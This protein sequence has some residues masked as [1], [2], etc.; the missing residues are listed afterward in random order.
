MTSLSTSDIRW[1]RYALLQAEQAPH[2]RWR[3][4]AVLIRGGSV[5]STGFNRYRNDPAQVEFG[6]A[7]YHAEEVAL[8]KAGDAEGSTI[9]VARI[10]RSG[11]L[12][13]AKPCPRCTDML[14]TEGVSTVVWSTPSGLSKT[15]VNR[16][17]DWP[18]VGQ[19]V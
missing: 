13:L 10:T 3:V 7:S 5:L 11:L 17:V 2:A 9:Y 4:G 16:L 6:H 19:V 12:G 14:I 1:F 8:R 15:R 18:Y